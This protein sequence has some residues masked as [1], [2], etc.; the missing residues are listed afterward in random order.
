MNKVL[1][2]LKSAGR[3]PVILPTS[4]NNQDAGQLQSITNDDVEAARNVIT[5]VPLLDLHLLVPIVLTSSVTG[6]GIGRLHALLRLLPVSN[7][8]AETELSITH[9]VVPY[10]RSLFH[11][12][13]VFAPPQ[14][15]RTASNE[16]TAAV[17]I[18]SGYLRYGLLEVGDRLLIGP[19][20]VDVLGRVPE[21]PEIHRP[22]SYHKSAKPPVACAKASWWPGGHC[23]DCAL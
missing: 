5:S 7:G 19:C 17:T 10:P 15:R 3:R 14:D 13:E 23:W 1:S 6:T 16:G 4:A 12:D 20:N 8:N 11:V 22:S 9:P 21:G 18:L 2:T